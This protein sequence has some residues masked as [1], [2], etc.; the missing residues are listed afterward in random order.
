MGDEVVARIS[1]PG[2]HWHLRWLNGNILTSLR[3]DVVGFL[4]ILGEDAVKTTSKLAS[5]SILFCLPRL[6]PAPH[7]LLYAE[8]PEEH[9]KLKAK[10]TGVHSGNQRDELN[11]VT[12]ALL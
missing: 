9:E 10:V 1:H 2:P 8:R 5:L 11:A 4:A 3:L 7:C 12:A 6:I